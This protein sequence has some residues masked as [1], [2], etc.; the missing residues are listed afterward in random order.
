[1]SHEVGGAARYL[2]VRLAAGSNEIVGRSRAHHVSI[3]ATLEEKGLGWT[4]C[5][6]RVYCRFARVQRA[7]N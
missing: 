3:I 1:M 7:R 2:P 5:A 4:T 6:Q